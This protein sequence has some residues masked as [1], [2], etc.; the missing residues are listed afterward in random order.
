MVTCHST[1][2]SSWHSVIVTLFFCQHISFGTINHPIILV[3]LSHSNTLFLEVK[4]HRN[5]CNHP[6]FPSSFPLP[7]GLFF[8]YFHFLLFLRGKKDNLS[9]CTWTTTVPS[10]SN[11]PSNSA[12]FNMSHCRIVL[13]IKIVQ[14]VF[15]FWHCFYC[16]ILLSSSITSQFSFS[17]L[18]GINGR[19][20]MGHKILPDSYDFPR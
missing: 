9:R 17:S 19:V 6:T 7:T 20:C 16:L 15:F 13:R 2:T 12:S 5:F 8:T 14:K 10:W 4:V 18:V 1:L 3:F 11:S